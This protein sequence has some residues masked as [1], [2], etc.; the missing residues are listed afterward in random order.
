MKVVVNL[1]EG[2]EVLG[3]YQGLDE[4]MVRYND[5]EEGTVEWAPADCVEV[6]PGFIVFHGPGG[7]V[8]RIQVPV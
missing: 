8:E 2:R 1:E 7:L 4:D 6:V 3:I 5:W